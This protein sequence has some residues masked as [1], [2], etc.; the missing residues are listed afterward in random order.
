MFNSPQTVQIVID[1]LNK[2]DIPYMVI[3][4]LAISLMGETRVTR[5]ADFKVSINMPLADFRKLVLGH[6]QERPSNIPAHKKS[7]H[8]IQIWAMPDIA[9]DLLVSIFDYEKEA[10]KRA[11][12]ADVMGIR[13]RVCTAED[14]II[15]K[16]TANR[17]KDWEDV[18]GILIRQRGKLDAKYV[19]NWLTQ[20]AEALESPEMLER[21]DKLY[22][23]VNT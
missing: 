21:F 6:F 4:G 1:F 12:W 16:V 19:R 22:V 20:F 15:H 10:I 14:L 18:E 17:S 7:P 13:A 5:D 23:E 11:V 8:V 2:N 9:V 3:G